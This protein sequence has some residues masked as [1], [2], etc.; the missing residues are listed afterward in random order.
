[1]VTK[2][3]KAEYRKIAERIFLEKLE[4]LTVMER[5]G[6]WIK[7]FL[8]EIEVLKDRIRKLEAEM[9]LLKRSQSLRGNGEISPEKEQGNQDAAAEILLTPSLAS[10]IRVS[11][12]C[13]IV[14][15]AKILGVSP[16]TYQNIERGNILPS[17]ELEAQILKFRYMKAT[18]RREILQHNGIF[19]KCT[20]KINTATV[21]PPPKTPEIGITIPE[22]REICETLHV[23]KA[24]LA[25]LLGVSHHTVSN[26]FYGNFRPGKEICEKLHRLMAE[27]PI[28]A[29][30]DPPKTK[31]AAKIPPSEISDLLKELNWTVAELS[32]YLHV[33][34]FRVY[35]WLAE[36]S[37][38][39]NAERNRIRS[40]Q[41]KVRMKKTDKVPVSTGEFAALKEKLQYSD[42]HLSIILRIPFAEVHSWTLGAAFPSEPESKKIRQ[43]REQIE[44]GKFVD[45]TQLPRISPEKIFEAR[46]RQ[47]LS[48]REF[49]HQMGVRMSTYRRWIYAKRG[50]TALEN[51][52]LWMIW[53]KP[54][55]VLPT[56]LTPDELRGIR[57]SHNLTRAA[58][59]AMLGTD[60]ANI[61]RYE[62]GIKKITVEISEKVK[63]L[64]DLVSNAEGEKS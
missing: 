64:F 50:P 40:L 47:H 27:K 1:M 8:S 46:K 49:L 30:D 25:E 39:T 34:Q 33:P 37:S 21:P 44:A 54:E 19:V 52:K 10:E 9:E 20:K 56:I 62:L 36:H 45:N 28:V 5:I 58:F 15:M 3:D 16:R 24:K 31:S 26:W 38:P 7:C 32:T 61:M 11:F 55:P 57:T 13:N 14:E 51:E 53:E 63:K 35:D 6:K 41:D 2:E 60:R 18:E 42:Y 59:A 17:P 4:N 23:S 22:L 12:G 29:P 48:L 43:L